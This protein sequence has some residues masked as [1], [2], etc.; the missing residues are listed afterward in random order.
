MDL[1]RVIV[2]GASAGGVEPLQRL[3][4]ALPVDLSAAVLVV[5]HLRADSFS[6][7]PAILDR[8]G[9]LPASR[10]CDREPIEPGRIYVSPPDV[11][12]VVRPGEIGLVHGPSENGH[13]PAIDPL[14]R[15][16]ARVYGRDAIGVVLSGVLDDGTAGLAEIK[17]AGGTA[18]VQSPADA[19]YSAMPRSALGRVDV[20]F[21]APGSDIG[22]VLARLVADA[23]PSDGPPTSAA[24]QTDPLE[25]A[26]EPDGPATGRHGG[27]ASGLSC[28]DCNGSLWE[29]REGGV[30]K[31]RCRVGHAWT[32]AALLNEQGDALEV[33][34]WTALRVI[35]ERAELAQRMRERAVDR[36]HQHAAK[37]FDERLK[38]F[39]HDARILRNVLTRPEL[40]ALEERLSVVSQIGGEEDA[41]PRAAAS[42]GQVAP[43]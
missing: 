37:L 31:F 32:E 20:D 35:G 16:A 3:V 19:L 13:R 6:A 4:A 5:L 15:T 30:S 22:A 23:P 34:L 18:V 25:Q 28:P 33:A 27:T 7:L 17:Q 36:G 9:A 11:H 12:L 40:A 39:D 43:G 42:G 21:V 10:A 26:V 2:V 41:L 29:T 8:A 24:A 38:E 14:F 1:R